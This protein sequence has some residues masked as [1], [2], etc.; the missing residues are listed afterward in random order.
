MIVNLY[1]NSI[2]SIF[3]E[4][5]NDTAQK[6]LNINLSTERICQ[7]K[8]RRNVQIQTDLRPPATIELNNPPKPTKR[9][10]LRN[11]RSQ[12]DFVDS[13]AS[14]TSNEYNISLD[15]RIR[16]FEKKFREEDQQFMHNFSNSFPTKKINLQDRFKENRKRRHSSISL[17]SP[18]SSVDSS[19]HRSVER[20][21]SRV[22][23]CTDNEI[24]Q[25]T[26]SGNN[27]SLAL[28][29]TPTDS[30]GIKADDNVA[31]ELMA[32]FGDE[33]ETDIF[34]EAINT[35]ERSHHVEHSEKI[36]DE[37]CTA[38]NILDISTPTNLKK[39]SIKVHDYTLELKNSIWPCELHMQRMKL[40]EALMKNADRGFRYSEH[41]KGK[42]EEL[43]GPEDDDDDNT[44]AP[45]R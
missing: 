13:A 31:E 5:R 40:H 12:T 38:K 8:T 17:E 7:R 26:N 45:Y 2:L 35:V 24:M 41:L 39:Q 37:D 4:I 33:E 30:V 18:H 36:N 34:G 29:A 32:L 11:V 14:S 22:D 21:D 19:I 16:I 27:A 43:F 10:H 23:S 1:R 44:F 15:E 9:K 20:T 25:L 28:L 6:K 3:A 42:F